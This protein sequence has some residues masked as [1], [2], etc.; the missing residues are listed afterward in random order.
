MFADANCGVKVGKEASGAK[1]RLKGHDETLGV[2]EF[3]IELHGTAG[4]LGCCAV[5]VLNIVRASG[6]SAPLRCCAVDV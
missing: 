6:A 5:D 1:E 3:F 4:A 2:L